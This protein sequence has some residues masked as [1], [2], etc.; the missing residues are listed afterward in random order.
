M[1]LP[2][3]LLTRTHAGNIARAPETRY[4]RVY[5]FLTPH[6]AIALHLQPA[7]GAEAAPRALIPYPKQ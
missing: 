6:F 2:P 3:K 7:G 1:I 4:S 5:A